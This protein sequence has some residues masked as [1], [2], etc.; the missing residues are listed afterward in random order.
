M[1]THVHAKYKIPK[2][3][4]IEYKLLDYVTEEFNDPES[5]RIW[6]HQGYTG[7]FTGAM[8]D[9]RS[10]QPTWNDK[11]ITIYQE[12]G[13]KDIGTSYY[14]MDTGTVLPT[15]AD[16]Y[17]R[18]VTLHNLQGRED[19]IRRAVVFLEDWKPGHYSEINGIGIVN[20]EA[21]TVIEWEYD[22]PHAAANIGIESRYTLQ[23]TGHV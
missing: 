23:I 2:F 17:A 5:L 14:R 13:W 22:A 18:Y 21:G 12:L 16:L 15:H 7:P 8:C 9:M 1:A 20:W 19:T 3:W 4:D 6:K 11:F 10:P